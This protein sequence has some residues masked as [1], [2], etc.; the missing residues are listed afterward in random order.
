MSKS[1]NERLNCEIITRGMKSFFFF[2]HPEK[3]P[4]LYDWYQ[5]KMIR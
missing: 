1:E 4:E 5:D 3:E 2:F